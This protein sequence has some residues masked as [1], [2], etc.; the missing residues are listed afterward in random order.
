MG[1]PIG[2]EEDISDFVG[3]MKVKLHSGDTVVLYTD[4]ITEA[5]NNVREQFGITRLCK[6]I[7]RNWRR[8]AAEIR[9]LIIDELRYHVGNNKVLDDVT[10]V[11]IKQK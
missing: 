4:G 5:Q 11:V 9:Q 2:L 8:T 6:S 1:F 7:S 10:L 3:E